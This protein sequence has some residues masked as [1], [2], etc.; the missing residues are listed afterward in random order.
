MHKTGTTAIQTSLAE[1]REWLRNKGIEYPELVPGLDE[2]RTAHH[3]VAHALVNPTARQR[4]R[5]LRFRRRIER[6]ARQARLT[7]VSAEPVYRHRLGPEPRD[8]ATFMEGHRAYLSRL[9]RYFRHFD[10]QVLLY[11][12]RPDTFMCSLYKEG[13]TTGANTSDFEDYLKASPWLVAYPERIAAFRDVLGRIEIR[14]Y[15]TECAR[16]LLQG[17]YAGLGLPPPLQAGR[18]VRVSPSDRATLWLRRAQ[19]E[20]PRARREHG[21]R[22]MFATSPE[23]APLFTEQVSSTLWPSDDVFSTFVARHRDAYEI[24]GFALPDPPGCRRTVWTDAMHAEA[25]KAFAAWEQANHVALAD[26]ARRGLR[27]YEH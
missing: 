22:V 8:T 15:E 16:G 7:L 12:R 6:A 17:F 5:L 25:E 11:L 3:A 10:P 20:S 18:D 19:T 9:K 2:P 1:N 21:F 14:V 13:V 26:R 4:I 27:H 24:G 23:S